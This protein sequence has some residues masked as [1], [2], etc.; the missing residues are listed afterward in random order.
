MKLRTLGI[1]IITIQGNIHFKYWL[2]KGGKK[3][4]IAYN[5]QCPEAEQFEMY[6]NQLKPSRAA[7]VLYAELNNEDINWLEGVIIR[8]VLIDLKG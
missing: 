4:D 6:A 7:I 8:L 5:V 1:Y 3:K 2:W